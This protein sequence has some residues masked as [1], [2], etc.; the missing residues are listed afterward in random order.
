MK[1]KVIGY[2]GER[3]KNLA[4]WGAAAY[5]DGDDL[6]NGI[7]LFRS[8]FNHDEMN[9]YIR[10]GSLLIFD[11]PI[12]YSDHPGMVVE[13]KSKYAKALNLNE[14]NIAY[15]D[16]EWCIYIFPTYNETIKFC[17]R[18]ASEM[19][20]FATGMLDDAYI[21]DHKLAPYKKH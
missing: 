11:Q 19:S 17:L 7:T 21:L 14:Q 13:I 5:L 1:Y 3:Y 2:E 9:E 8:K 20:A 18:V 15:Q 6:V 16:L 12:M 4:S 10:D